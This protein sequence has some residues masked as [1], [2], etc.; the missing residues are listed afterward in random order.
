MV[1]I[2]KLCHPINILLINNLYMR[3]SP[4][5]VSG[6]LFIILIIFLFYNIY[7]FHKYYYVCQN[8]SIYRKKV[9]FISL[10]GT[11]FYSSLMLHFKKVK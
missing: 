1:I 7:F 8:S 10:E 6:D 4:Y 2:P 9:S 3:V 11:I 5:Y